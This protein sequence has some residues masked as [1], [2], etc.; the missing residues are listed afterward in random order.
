MVH[1]ALP[2]SPPRVP[3][4][5][6]Q[7]AENELQKT[8]NLHSRSYSRP[9]SESPC[10][11]KSE[12]YVFLLS[13]RSNTRKYAKSIEDYSVF[14]VPED[15]TNL[16]F[17]GNI[18]FC[19]LISTYFDVPFLRRG[20]RNQGGQMVENSKEKLDFTEFRLMGRTNKDYKS[21]HILTVFETVA[22]FLEFLLVCLP[23]SIKILGF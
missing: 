13:S 9:F 21:K 11:R 3:P 18:V 6:L 7:G 12:V 5:L 23:I 2:G 22:S 16:T 17:V 4:R 1:L 10:S 14:R 8:L 19:R 20:F 15:P